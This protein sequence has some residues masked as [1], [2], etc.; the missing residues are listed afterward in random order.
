MGMDDDHVGRRPLLG[1]GLGLLA[2]LAGCSGLFIEPEP[3]TAASGETATPG[4]TATTTTATATERPEPTAEPAATAVPLASASVE[5]RNRA[6]VVRRSRLEAFALVDY[7]FDVEN[8]GR[9]TIRDVEF[10]VDVR[11]EHDDSSRVVAT[12][13]HRFVFDPDD[14]ADDSGDESAEGL[15]V[16]EEDRVRETVRFERDG[17]AEESTD[18]GRFDLELSVRRIRYL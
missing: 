11:Y 15:Q 7:R 6:L 18:I 16:D 9:E 2:S 4:E 14:E 1:V 10:R 17:R 13:F 8:V 3:T 5:V 12:D